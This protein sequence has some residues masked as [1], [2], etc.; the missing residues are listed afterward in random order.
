LGGGSGRAAAGAAGAFRAEERRAGRL[1][2]A[3]PAVRGRFAMLRA[4][5]LGARNADAAVGG[6][7][8]WE[9][10]CCH[11]SLYTFF[12]HQCHVSTW[13]G[14]HFSPISRSSARA[15]CVAG[16]PSRRMRTRSVACAA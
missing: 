3:A 14:R 2:L 6:R 11:H 15:C 9:E 1:P 13:Q 12:N 10:R 8:S 7:G 4:A 16:A 5:R